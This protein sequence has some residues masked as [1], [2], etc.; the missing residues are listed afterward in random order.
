MVT[1]PREAVASLRSVHRVELHRVL[2]E[3]LDSLSP[4][5]RA[6]FVLNDV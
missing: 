6:A 2:L 1:L 3:A 4:A 5:E